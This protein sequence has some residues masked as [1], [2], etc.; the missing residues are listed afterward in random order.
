MHHNTIITI[1]SYSYLLHISAY[2]FHVPDV[3]EHTE[4]SSIAT[5]ASSKGKYVT[6]Y[7]SG[8]NQPAGITIDK[9]G[10]IFIAD[11]GYNRSF[12][13]DTYGSL[14]LTPLL[15]ITADNVVSTDFT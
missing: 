1:A 7:N 15:P 13:W 5:A 6:Q 3:S 9:E 10:N 2:S 4:Y 8:V 12:L 14:S 11:N